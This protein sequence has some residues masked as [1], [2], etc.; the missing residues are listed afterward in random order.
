MSDLALEDMLRP[1]RAKVLDRAL[2]KKT[3]PLSAAKVKDR[4]QI[5]QIR[6]TLKNDLLGAER[7]QSVRGVLESSGEF[8][9]ALLL[10]RSIRPEGLSNPPLPKLLTHTR[11]RNMDI[12]DQGLCEEPTDRCHFLRSGPQLR[13]LDILCVGVLDDFSNDD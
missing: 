7:V 5:T 9:K 3:L 12:R 6:K 8:S 13:V 4:T 10:K 2:F 1:P 11:S